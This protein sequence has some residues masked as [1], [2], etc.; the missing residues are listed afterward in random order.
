DF[1]VKT[2]L[3]EIVQTACRLLHHWADVL[4][5]DFTSYVEKTTE[6]MLALLRFN[7]HEGVCA[8][9]AEALPHLLEC[10]KLLGDKCVRQMWQNM[11]KELFSVI[12][13]KY[14]ED[15]D[16]YILIRSSDIVR[17]LLVTYSD[18][19]LIYF[20][21]L[22]PHFYRLLERQRSV[23]DRQWSLHVWNDIIQY[24]GQTS[25]R[26]QQ[27]FLQRM[28]ESVQDVSAEVNTAPYYRQLVVVRNC[29]IMYEVIE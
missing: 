9:V 29:M 1:H 26:Y 28:A 22:A 14:E 17:S 13:I 10:E 23:S 5:N 2:G 7:C 11:K 25:F 3:L 24:T 12:K 18:S 19:Y 15:C 4:K 6:L 27:S 8:A 16:A 21:S 20:D